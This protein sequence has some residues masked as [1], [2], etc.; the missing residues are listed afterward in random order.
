[1]WS[2]A[3]CAPFARCAASIASSAM[4]TARSPIACTWIWNP[5]L[6]SAIASESNAA[7]GEIRWAAIV[8]VEIRLEQRGR[9]RL[10]DAVGEDL[11]A[12]HAQAAAIELAAQADH[13]RNLR[14]A[15]RGIDVDR[16]HDARSE[17]A[18][19]DRACDRRRG[20]RCRRS[21]PA[22]RRCRTS[23]RFGAHRPAPPRAAPASP[24][25]ESPDTRSAASSRSVPDGF[26][27][28][29]R[30]MRPFGTS[31]VRAVMC[32]SA[33]ARE[34]SHAECPSAARTY[35]GRS[36]MRLSSSWRLGFACGNTG[37]C[38]PCPRNHASCGCAFAHFAIESATCAGVVRSSS[39]HSFR[40]SPVVTG[41]TCES[42]KAGRS[43]RPPQLDDLA[44]SIQ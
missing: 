20:C 28:A 7:R 10:D 6:S 9:V 5:A 19:A 21:P 25:E 22:F 15:G 37:S 16:R 36:G 30:S 4:R 31:C 32:A 8:R 34:F 18:A 38:H 23:S 11:G 17:R 2:R 40:R 44:S 39:A 43:M 33:R 35:A 29:S 41:C 26:P 1:M 42:R 14:H 27:A 12:A 24:S 13:A 3:S